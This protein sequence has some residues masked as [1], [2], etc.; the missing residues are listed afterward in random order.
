MTN[1]HK[2]KEEL[3][4]E[5]QELQQAYQLLKAKAETGLPDQ[6]QT[7]AVV[8]AGEERFQL[9]FN[10][11]PLG[12]QSLDFDGNFIEVNQQW[13]DTL[14]YGREEV[15]GKW[16]GDFLTPAFQDGFR[17]RFPIFKAQGK[18][19]SEFEMIHKNGSVLF[20]AFDGRIGYDNEGNFMQTHCILQDI[21]SQKQA[22]KELL[23]SQ[24]LLHAME[25]AAKIGGWEFE[26]ETMVQT[27]TDEVFHILE[28]DTTQGAPDVPLGI[29]FIAPE[30]QPMALL[31]I[32]RAI[33]FGEPYNQEWEVI[34]AKGNKRWINA[35]ATQHRENGKTKFVSGSFQD[36]T[37]RKQA[38]IAL[39]ES[40]ENLSTTLHSIGDG[41]ISTD[42]N[43]LIIQMN[44]V[45]ETLC[46]WKLAEAL[47]KPLPEVFII[48]NAGSRHI[49]ADPVK[50][51]LEKG[52]IVGLANHTVLISRN[53]TEY[54]ISDS[55]APIKNKEGKITGVVLVFSDVTETYITQKHIKESEERYRS[56]MLNLEAGI[57]V[58]APDTSIVMNNHRATVLLGLSDDQMK[59]KAAIDPAWKFIHEDNRP[60]T[61]D[62]Y[63]VNRIV[64]G[65]QAIKNQI[66]GIQQPGKNDIVW[67]TVNGFP[68]L[69]TEG[70]ITEIVISFIDFTLQKLAENSL[71]ESEERFKALHNASFGGITIHDKGQ[72]I[73]CNQGLSDITGYSYKEL[74]GMD[75]LLLVAPESRELVKEKINS[76]FEKPY[77]ALGIRKNGEIFPLRLEAKN[78]PY[79][80]KMV[81]TVEF[82]DITETKK[83]E[84]LLH[85]KTAEIEA[86]NE[87]YQQINEE[88]NQT[89]LELANAIEIAEN[90][91]ARLKM[92]LKVSKSGAWDWDILKNT[93]YWSDEFL[94]LFGLPPKTIAGFEAWTKALHPDDIESASTKIKEAI[95]NHTE[96][97]NDYRI[98]LPNN[99]IR[100]IRAT[101]NVTYINNN[102]Q[103]MI[104]LC[105]DI[106]NQKSAEQ[107]LYDA[108]EQAEESE[109]KY[110]LAE[111]DLLEAQKLANIGSWHWDLKTGLVAWSKEL[112]NINGHN[113][114]IPVPVFADMALYY[115]A[116]SWK[117]L[118]EAVARTFNSG[119]PYNLDFEM[120]KPDGTVIFANT[121]GCANYDEAGEMVSLHG[122]VQDITERKRLEDV[123]TFLSTS[124]Y[125]G[126]DKTFFESLAEYLAE[127]LDSEYVCIDKLEGDGLTAQTVAIFNDGK[128]D[129]N[130]SYT[131][132]QTPCGDVVG[133]NICCFPENVCQLFPDDAALQELQ[134]HS[135][136]GT[137]L[138]S[139]D[140]KPIGLIAIIGRKPLKNTTFAENVLKLVAI[141]AAGELERI[142]AEDG[143]KMAKLK[144]EESEAFFR[145]IFENSPVGKSITGIDGSL[146]TNKSFS[147]M[148]GYSLEE[149]QAKNFDAIT[150]PDDIQ[151]SKE[152]VE[153]LLK[154][155]EPV[156]R[157]EKKYIHKNGSV[158]FSEV[159]TTL[160]KNR[161]G[162]PLFFITSVQDITERKQSEKVLKESEERFKNMFERHSSIMLLIEPESGRIIGANAASASFYGYSKSKLLTMRIDEINMLSPEQV[163]MERELAVH[164]ERT[165][166]VFPHK[167][168]SGE[169][170]TV[171]VHSSPI[172]FQDQQ[173]L[174]SIIHDIT[175]R[176]HLEKIREIQYNIATAEVT[177]DSIEQLLEFVRSELSQLFDTTNFFAALYNAKKNTLKKLHWIDEKD[178]FEEWDAAKSFSGYVVRTGKILLLNK[179]E[180]AKLAV[181]QNIP[182]MGEPAECWLGV[183]LLVDKK[184]IGVLVI[185]SYTDSKAY[186]ASCAMLFEQVAYDLSVFIEK[187]RI[188]NDLNVAKLQAEESDR[189]KSAFLA[190]M[191]HEIRTPMNGILGFAEILKDPELTGDQQKEY[192]KIIEKSGNRMLNIINDIVDISKIESGL[193]KTDI[194]ESDVNEQIEYI[195]TFFKP[196]VEAKGMK[197]SFNTTLSAKEATILT[198]RE[199]VYAILTNLVKNAIKYSKQGSIEL[200]YKI[201]ETQCIASLQFYVKDTGIGIPVARQEAI[202]ERFIQADIT[203]KMAR[204]GAGLGLAITKSYVEMLGGEIWVESQEGEGSTFYFTLPYNQIDETNSSVQSAVTANE[205]SNWSKKLKILIAED[206]EASE[207]LISL[208]V[209]TFGREILR[210]ETGID[211]IESC[212]NYPDIDLILMDIQMPVMGGYEATRQIRGFNQQVIIIAQTAYG[213]S[214]DREKAIEAGCNDYISKPINKIDLLALIQKYFGK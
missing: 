47:G 177:T 171:E 54:Q 121:R 146:K 173:I 57:V 130:V 101:G 149:F 201:V 160:Q 180:I 98:V 210:V 117:V 114:D 58:H 106:T 205:K 181:E 67:V 8:K 107:E 20:I 2:S 97:L 182:I 65:R 99:E 3:I 187:A 129:A 179:Q 143:L 212:R 17:K 23:K 88:L 69:D 93:F 105:L 208:M 96:L 166:F 42:T 118:N 159:V 194:K 157:F 81:R 24:M 29:G 186:D 37:E 79:K 35:I 139:F 214:G 26:V 49:V 80:G 44:P 74:T 142:Q 127:T 125:P 161:D 131:L 71:R 128:F 39:A 31:G 40:E 36:I 167:L 192:I 195:Y 61:L 169:V 199:K 28:I 30:Y 104:G 175:E 123:H 144:A 190:N 86:Q 22:E 137:T 168:A 116:E 60:F 176:K 6:K 184:A 136:I 50:Q 63:P 200:G 4:I 13:L 85:E 87:E 203:D 111:I 193:M 112:Y 141:R 124:G 154:G 204:Q 11:A 153:S 191:S 207:M 21:T 213:L 43:G 156:I 95:E 122:T 135:Y 109:E 138:W 55:A 178:N 164:E 126:S 133:K 206:D 189:L 46:G 102:P 70:Q 9:L 25:K 174:F 33:E 188:L 62:E 152:V 27:W 52:E 148:L 150:H 147:D 12:Y 113:P 202:F 19:H 110:R 64:T 14:G 92:A 119:E 170:R 103:R 78:I 83:A 45:A 209:N 72:I 34:T 56:L 51:V 5:L 15:I 32:Q 53:G 76:G 84:L 165:Y 155:E 66:L 108:K 59:G 172:I 198:D 197:L 1:Q 16:F 7:E 132:K 38:E 10:K 68:V 120:V 211:A 134:A 94:Q 183:P 90:N 18:I 158:V 162:K 196:E 73:E 145:S 115:T 163:K 48:I 82:R 100:W 89:N 41:V 140:G 185:Q 77:E 151:K 91:E 75:G